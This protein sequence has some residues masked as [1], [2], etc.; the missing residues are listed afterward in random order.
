MDSHPHSSTTIN[1]EER[2]PPPPPPPP[3][4][5][6]N[7][8]LAAIDTSR[9]AAASIDN[10]DDDNDNDNGDLRRLPAIPAREKSAASVLSAFRYKNHI[11]HRSNSTLGYN[12]LHDSDEDTAS[13]AAATAT[14]ATAAMKG[15]ND[16]NIY[17]DDYYHDGKHS[18]HTHMTAAADDQSSP[19]P[20]PVLPPFR[21]QRRC[22]GCACRPKCWGTCALVTA[23]LLVG[24][25]IAGFFLFPR[26]PSVDISTPF[27]PSDPTAAAP[28]QAESATWTPGV[29]MTGSVL[30]ASPTAPFILEIGV[31]VNATIASDNYVGYHV[32]KLTVEGLLKDANG[33]VI[34]L[35]ATGGGANHLQAGAIITDASISPR[36]TTI[37]NLPISI[38]YT[39]VTPLTIASA[40]NDPVIAV[41]AR[42]CGGLPGFATK[43]PGA[44]IDL[45]VTSTIDIRGVSWIGYRPK[46]EKDVSF[47]CP[48]V[49]S[50]ALAAAFSDARNAVVDAISAGLANAGN[51]NNNAAGNDQ[52][53][54]AAR[55]TVEDVLPVADA[56][57]A[58][59]GAAAGG[60]DANGNEE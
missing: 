52:S 32:N 38:N 45:H 43:V 15:H 7:H 24:L 57:G 31:G 37:L 47:A 13:A 58:V 50:S 6:H 8:S 11:G 16:D 5:A 34:D 48:A 18:S 59:A 12:Q 26:I 41:L 28:F 44:K 2:P 53:A 10:N 42:A 36:T 21:K 29:K 20:P 46:I 55:P 22:C 9:P 27:V 49:V 17:H 56:G 23:L 51:N 14:A 40:V 60:N 25:A 4:P 1:A 35:T 33:K 39:L 30:A 3:P 19:L 54:P